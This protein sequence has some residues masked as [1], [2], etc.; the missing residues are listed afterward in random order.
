MRIRAAMQ[1]K[2][3]CSRFYPCSLARKREQQSSFDAD[4]GPGCV[5]GPRIAMVMYR[6]DVTSF[7]KLERQLELQEAFNRVQ[8]YL[9]SSLMRAFMSDHRH[10]SVLHATQKVEGDQQFGDRPAWFSD[11]QAS[12]N[13]PS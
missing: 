12:N 3:V 2:L 6:N 1:A 5:A 10:W 4:S 7:Q 13:T 8:G 9:R 11:R